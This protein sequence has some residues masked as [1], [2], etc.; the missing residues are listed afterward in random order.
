[1][2]SQSSNQGDRILALLFVLLQ[3]GDWLTREQIYQRVTAYQEAPSERARERAFDRDINHLEMSHFQ[4]SKVRNGT[5]P[6]LYKA[7]INASEE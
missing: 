3:S 2:A 7:S 4:I 5:H 1:M 6:A